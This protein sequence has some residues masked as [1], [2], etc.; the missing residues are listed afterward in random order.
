VKKVLWVL[1]GLVIAALV[2]AYVYRDTLMLI[3]YSANMKPVKS[4]ADSIPPAPPDYFNK[5]HW[6]A[7]PEREDGADYIPAG[8]TDEQASASADVF[9]VHPT[10][11]LRNTGW[12]APMGHESSARWVDDAIMSGQANV[13][14]G[15]ARVYAP[16]YRQAQIY[17]FL[18]L[19]DGGNEAL[20]LAY[21]DI[22][23]AFNHYMTEFNNGRPFILAGHSQGA[24]LT[25]WLLERK[26]TGT[27]LLDR[28]VAAY[29]IGFPMRTDELARSLPD[30]P[31]CESPL[32]TACLAS[33]N[34]I[35]DGY[36]PLE[37]TKNNICVNPLTWTSDGKQGKFQDNE[38][39]LTVKSEAL[40]KAISDARCDDGM[41]YVSKIRTDVY[42]SLPYM[43]KG[44]H[45]L[46]DYALFWLNIRENVNARVAA[47]NAADASYISE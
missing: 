29:P 12:N 38:G 42:D 7:L 39:A 45:H 9:F 28:M 3:A 22:E 6:A 36:R 33:W 35:S 25:R 2:A 19:E 5:E 15:A 44:N 1:G 8:L 32:Q 20:E 16:R 43:G 26:I 46:L 37:P 41:L 40:M 31:V 21:T 14:N 34:T 4:F 23:T 10:T 47:F 17:A 11:F 18:A 13:F 24:L 30:I 27:A